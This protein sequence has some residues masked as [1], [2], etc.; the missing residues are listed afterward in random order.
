[1]KTMVV[2]GLLGSGKTT[3][4]QNQVRAAAQKTVVLV[5]DFGTAGIDGEIFSA[6]GIEAVELPSGCICCTLK[7]ELI[8]T[9]K[10]IADEFAPEHLIIEPSGVASPSSVLEALQGAQVGTATVVGVIDATEFTELY[11]SGMYGSFFEDQITSSDVILVNKADLTDEEK[12]LDTIHRIESINDRAVLVRTEYGKVNQ[13]LSEAFSNRTIRATKSPLHFETLSF[14]LQPETNFESV[15]SLLD[16]LS[17]GRYGTVVR[18]K[19]LLMT[20]R[21]PYRFDVVYGRSD[22]TPFDKPIADSRM[23]I[24]GDALNE[25]V[26]RE[27]IRQF[28]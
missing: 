8:A 4:I 11:A 12:V 2:C 16:K 6:D 18:A 13:S 5:N 20:D 27:V 26:L 7:V 3:F 22:C 25:I 15:R 14:R 9:I 19:A 23:V 24:I 1:M 21:G 17:Q 28:R 10:K